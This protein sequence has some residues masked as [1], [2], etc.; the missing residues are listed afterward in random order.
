MPLLRAVTEQLD[1]LQDGE[2]TRPTLIET[3]FHPC[4]QRREPSGR[5]SIP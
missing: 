5:P 2:P 1:R 4:T 3:I